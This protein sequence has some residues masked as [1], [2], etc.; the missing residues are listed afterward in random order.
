[1]FVPVCHLR[2]AL[3]E[4]TNGGP[5]STESIRSSCAFSRLALHDELEAALAQ[6]FGA[7]AVATPPH[8]DQALSRVEVGP[9]Y[10]WRCSTATD[11]V[12]ASVQVA[13]AGSCGSGATVRLFPHNDLEKLTPNSKPMA[14]AEK[15]CGSSQGWHSTD[16]WNGAPLQ[17]LM[18]RLDQFPAFPH[19]YVDDAHGTCWVGDRGQGYVLS[20][21][22]LHE[23]MVLATSLN[24]AFSAAG[25]SHCDGQPRVARAHPSH[26]RPPFVFGSDPAAHDGGIHRIGQA[27]FVRRIEAA[28][29]AAGGQHPGGADRPEGAWTSRGL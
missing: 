6:V 14:A 8:G 4:G 16:E 5:D 1:M 20:Q 28:P 13:V 2:D 21:V 23:R 29:R 3:I 25:G 12:H 22:D 15:R 10:A 24:K 27:P 11:H 9:G 18:E 26:R 19:L 17:A 7:H